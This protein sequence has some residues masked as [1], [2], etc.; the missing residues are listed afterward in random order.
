MISNV[1]SEDF[2]DFYN[3]ELL[4]DGTFMNLHQDYNKSVTNNENSF[5]ERSGEVSQGRSF[6]AGNLSTALSTLVNSTFIFKALLVYW[7]HVRNICCN[8]YVE[9]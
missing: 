9:L 6:D 7:F 2:E 3:K 1:T 4:S 5:V 8:T